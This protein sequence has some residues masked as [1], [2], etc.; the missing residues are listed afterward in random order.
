MT[1]R[2]ILLSSVIRV[3]RVAR[4]MI[5]TDMVHSAWLSP[6][7]GY[8][9]IPHKSGIPFLFSLDF[10]PLNP[11]LSPTTPHP[12]SWSGTSCPLRHRRKLRS[13]MY[14][15]ST[16]FYGC[17]KR[18]HNASPA[19]LCLTIRFWQRTTQAVC[20][21]SDNNTGG[22]DTGHIWATNNMVQYTILLSC[23]DTI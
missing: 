6:L 1:F 18:T 10:C 11:S 2:R 4:K 19:W 7:H 8:L 9:M 22:W 16:G 14:K 17:K 20:T 15:M 5:R 21:R 12:H 3:T 23:S 13:S